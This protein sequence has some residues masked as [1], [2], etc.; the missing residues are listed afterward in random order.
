MKILF[1]ASSGGH[2]VQL[3]SLRDWWSGHDRRWVTFDTEDASSSLTGERVI[4]AFHPTTRHLGNLLRNAVLAH[5]V[6][7]AWRPD[8]VVSTGAAVALPFFLKAKAVGARTCYIEVFDRMDSRTLTG[9]LCYP[10]SDGFYVQWE[11]QKGLYP[12]AELIGQTL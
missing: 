2:L 5:R 8:V 3:V 12:E 1:V 7:S 11:E 6:I 10:I 9:R 4:H